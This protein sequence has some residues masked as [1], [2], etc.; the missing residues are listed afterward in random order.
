MNLWMAGIFGADG[1]WQIE[2]LHGE[3]GG[4]ETID[5]MQV[6]GFKMLRWIISG[7]LLGPYIN[8]T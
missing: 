1:T 2:E 6:V 5:V 3:G 4:K 7:Y 8:D